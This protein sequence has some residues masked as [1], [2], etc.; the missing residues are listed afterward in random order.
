MKLAAELLS[1]ATDIPVDCVPP[2][3]HDEMLRLHG[4]ARISI[5]LSIGDAISTSLL[6]AMAM[7]SFPIQ[8]RTSCG[9]EWIKCGESG[10]LVHPEDPAE[11]ARAIRR[12]IEDDALVDRAAEIN[13]RTTIERLDGSVIRG[14][15]IAA[16]ERVR[17]G[18]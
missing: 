15:A 1:C 7:G 2:V 4:S 8:S 5:G 16:Y 13:E 14:Q 3:P 10:I 11:I 9:D 18:V 6:E 17:A 12:A